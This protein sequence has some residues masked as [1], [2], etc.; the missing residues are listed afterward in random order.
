MRP[1]GAA[2][3]AFG[4]AKRP[5]SRQLPQSARALHVP[6]LRMPEVRKTQVEYRQN[7]SPRPLTWGF[8]KSG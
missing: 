4:S 8:K 1:H 3:Q 7:I 5:G 2:G 6:D